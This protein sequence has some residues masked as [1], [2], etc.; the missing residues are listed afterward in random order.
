[1]WCDAEFTAA[2]RRPVARYCRPAHRQAVHRARQRRVRAAAVDPALDAALDELAR[3]VDGPG[4]PAAL[5]LWA[6]AVDA[7]AAS[8]RPTPDIEPVTLRA[9]LAVVHTTILANGNGIHPKSDTGQGPI[10]FRRS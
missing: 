1:M 6:A 5:A 2:D 4:E 7:V 3:P 10:L 8:G 9:E